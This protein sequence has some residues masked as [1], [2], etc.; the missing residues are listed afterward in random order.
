MQRKPLPGDMP[1]WGP[2]SK[3][4]VSGRA[5]LRWLNLRRVIVATRDLTAETPNGTIKGFINAQ[6]DALRQAEDGGVVL[7]GAAATTPIWKQGDLS[8]YNVI[9]MAR[10]MALRKHKKVNQAMKQVCVCVCVCV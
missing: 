4:R 8:L 3:P 7:E 9:N 10:R 6:H 2:P 1:S 5:Q